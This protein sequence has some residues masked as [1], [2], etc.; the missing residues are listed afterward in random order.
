MPLPPITEEEATQW[1][2]LRAPAAPRR[3]VQDELLANPPDFSQPQIPLAAPAAP[4]PRM[5]APSP[6][7]APPPDLASLGVNQF[8]DKQLSSTEAM[9]ACGP[10]AAIAFSQRMGRQP[11][12]REAVDIAQSNGLWDSENGMHGPDAQQKLLSLMG[13]PTRKEDQVNWETVQKDVAGGNPVIV[14]S[15]GHYWQILG[16]RPEDGRYRVGTSGTLYKGGSDWMTPE[17]MGS[18]SGKPRA[19]LYIDNPDTPTPSV[20]RVS[21]DPNDFRAYARGAAQRNGID[22]QLF[23]RQIQQENGFK[24]SG[25]SPAG[26]QGIAGIVPSA[27]PG[28]DVNDPH[29]SLDYAASLM[30]GYVH[31]YGDYPTALAAYNAGPGNVA[32]YGGV[33][34]FEETQRYIKTIM[35]GNPEPKITTPV[36][37]ASPNLAA[38]TQQAAQQ[39][40]S[41]PAMERPRPSNAIPLYSPPTPK[42]PAPIVQPLVTSGYNPTTPVDAEAADRGNFPMMGSAPPTPPPFTNQDRIAELNQPAQ[43]TST[44]T[45][46]NGTQTISAPSGLPVMVSTPPP[47]DLSGITPSAPTPPTLPEPQATSMV[48]QRGVQPQPFEGARNFADTLGRAGFGVNNP[49]MTPEEMADYVRANP[50]SQAPPVDIPSAMLAT[51]NQ[52]AFGSGSTGQDIPHEMTTAGRQSVEAIPGV[53]EWDEA[54]RGPFNLSPLDVAQGV[55]DLAMPLPAEVYG[56]AGRAAGRVGK[57]I[58]GVAGRAA[59]TGVED[60]GRAAQRSEQAAE[61][62]RAAGDTAGELAARREAAAVRQA[63]APSAGLESGSLRTLRD[64]TIDQ[65]LHPEPI[66]APAPVGEAPPPP[67]APRPSVYN[68]SPLYEQGLRTITQRGY[69]D[70]ASLERLQTTVQQAASSARDAS[71]RA[72]LELPRWIDKEFPERAP[73]AGPEPHVT[74]AEFEQATG[75]GNE[76]YHAATVNIPLQVAGETKPLPPSPNPGSLGAKALEQIGAQPSKGPAPSMREQV[77]RGLQFLRY[78]LVND[79]APLEEANARANAAYRAAH[80]VDMPPEL[81]AANL[82]RLTGGGYDIAKQRVQ[83]ELQPAVDMANG[84]VDALKKLLEIRDNL[85]VA[86]SAGQK[87]EAQVLAQTFTPPPAMASDLS[88]AKASLQ[89]LQRQATPDPK[90]IRATQRRVTSLQNQLD[91]LELQ[92]KARQQGQATASRQAAEAGRK[93]SGGVDLAQSRAAL[94]DLQAR[95]SPDEWRDVQAAA[96]AVDK[97]VAGLRQ[98]LVDAGVISPQMAQELAQKYPHYVPTRILDYLADPSRLPTGKRINLSDTGLRAL[99]I[100]GTDKAREDVLQ[101]LVRLNFETE[102][103]AA[104][105]EVARAVA[106][107]GTI[108]PALA[109]LMR[110]VTPGTKLTKNEIAVHYFEQGVKQEVAV[111]KSL[112]PIVSFAN[113]STGGI[114]KAFELGANITRA[115]ATS[116]NPLFLAKNAILDVPGHV[117]DTTTRYGV[118]RLPIV[119]KTLAESYVDTF[120]GLL[121]NQ[122]RGAATQRYLSGGGGQFGYFSGKAEDVGRM[123]REIE[124]GGGYVLDNPK[125]IAHFLWELTPNVGERIELAPRISAMRLAERYG[126]NAQDAVLAGRET[127]MDFSR[128]GAFTKAVNSFVPFFNVSTQTAPWLARTI[129]RNPKGGMVAL[130]T[131][132]VAPT[133]VAEAWNRS[134][135]ERAA[136]YAEVPDYIKRQGIVI[137]APTPTAGLDEQGRTKLSYGLIPMRNFGGIVIPVREAMARAMGTDDPR[138]W[139]GLVSDM[140]GSMSPIQTDNPTAAIGGFLPTLFGTALQLTVDKDFFRN[141]AINT[142]AANDRA[143]A[144]S[145]A[146]GQ[147]TGADPA[148]VEFAVRDVANGVGGILLAAGD[149]A[150]KVKDGQP[151]TGL[152]PSAGQLPGVGGLAGAF[153]K[154]QGGQ[155]EQNLRDLRAQT[156]EA[157]KKD[158][159]TAVAESPRYR[160]MPPTAVEQKVSDLAGSLATVA[161]YGVKTNPDSVIKRVQRD[162]AFTLLTPAQ[163]AEKLHEV[164][165]LLDQR[166]QG[167]A[168]RQGLADERIR[169]T[170]EQ[171]RRAS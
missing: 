106:N 41:V 31:Q 110:P 39:A 148:Q 59:T 29:A 141:R 52:P 112:E 107:W 72:D 115:T 95:L 120:A 128:G 138:E 126:A 155:V 49:G 32:K 50:I 8:G 73:T 150:A 136:A 166:R 105:N 21:A 36:E 144:P 132:V 122:Y 140:V 109:G 139:Q 6:S 54:H 170:R 67:S 102:R 47:L 98:R 12:L 26:A 34:P 130:S 4:A 129:Q 94:D 163:Q 121:Q 75:M 1:Y 45:A 5:G 169:S 85:D 145:K 74:A 168:E 33:P 161:V 149:M 151:L 84:H 111:D 160:T 37:P 116:H 24:T 89:A 51:A 83:N 19:A 81:Q 60:L 43:G 27:H 16:Y 58:E 137:M 14:D 108:D 22:P 88:R 119:A 11:T 82:D 48:N 18:L 7:S 86:A 77:T 53:K 134:D 3:R 64:E 104:K 100:Q 171:I 62:A 66:H 162:P 101:S 103:R 30:A 38:L 78:Q 46:P 20:A 96:D 55:A 118:H 68:G 40:A 143:S 113:S 17:E 152:N 99:T 25:S 127:T 61:V 123:T 146:I 65:R 42:P 92:W 28:V 90:R 93:F 13:V 133:L 147:L 63:Q 71:I 159:M 114:M 57:G 44:T 97:H 79:R 76:P 154:S 10:A 125:D 142:N 69:T 2:A 158:L 157:Y 131:M 15:P 164:R 87:V 153:V 35:A 56:A 23:E 9:A 91:A 167:G 124:R 165:A 156:A 117:F 70:P 135:P 80:G